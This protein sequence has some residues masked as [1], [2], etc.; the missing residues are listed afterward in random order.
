MQA[1]ELFETALGL[2]QNGVSLNSYLECLYGLSA[3]YL[4]TA[5]YEKA[6]SI[7]MVA[8][9]TIEKQ[10]SKTHQIYGTRL[11]NLAQIRKQQ[12]RQKEAEHHL[13]QA[14]EIIEKSLNATTPELIKPLTD[15][16]LLFEEQHHVAKA[17]QSWNRAIAICEKHFGPEDPGIRYL[18]EL[19][20]KAG[21]S[22]RGPQKKKSAKTNME[23]Q[24]LPL[25]S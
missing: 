9:A 10:L 22:A 21:G 15:L 3:A 24:Q 8:L 12:G 5:D 2:A 19:R 1:Q 6:E 17:L 16:G 18:K 4:E 25:F 20:Q 23:A 11:T 7:E 13:L 14:I